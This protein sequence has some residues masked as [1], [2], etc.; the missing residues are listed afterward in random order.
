MS[1][2][3][4]RSQRGIRGLHPDAQLLTCKLIIKWKYL[5]QDFH[6]YMSEGGRR[7]QI[8][9]LIQQLKCLHDT[10]VGSEKK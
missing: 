4:E 8:Q 1:F 10:S 3:L 5:E 7:I 2:R 6:Y 9:I